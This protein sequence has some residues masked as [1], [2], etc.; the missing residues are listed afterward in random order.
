MDVESQVS[1]LKVDH[2]GVFASGKSDVSSAVF[3][4]VSLDEEVFISVSASSS[5]VAAFEAGLD[6]GIWTQ[7]LRL[8]S[9]KWCRLSILAYNYCDM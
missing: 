5:R 3:S 1:A 9:K 7:R 8:S 4:A 6:K 2:Q